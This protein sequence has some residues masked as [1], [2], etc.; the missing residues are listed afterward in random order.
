MTDEEY[1]E[2][3]VVAADSARAGP[4]R[5]WDASDAITGWGERRVTVWSDRSWLS[6]VFVPELGALNPAHYA[7]AFFA[8]DRDRVTWRYFGAAAATRADGDANHGLLE[9]IVAEDNARVGRRAVL[10]D[11]GSPR[12]PANPEPIVGGLLRRIQ[13]SPKSMPPWAEESRALARDGYA[14]PWVSSRRDEVR[15]MGPVRLSAPVVVESVVV[16]RQANHPRDGDFRQERAAT[17]G[18]QQRL[19]TAARDLPET[20]ASRLGREW[21]EAAQAT[22][23]NSTSSN[24]RN[25]GRHLPPSPVARGR[26]M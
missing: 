16:E 15:T 7:T 24:E 10:V 9:S 11:P 4:G 17:A 20:A 23:A 8:P 2:P 1:R 19:D 5:N 13:S 18:G 6:T 3:H 22:R 25:L 14:A 26:R 21:E 12:C